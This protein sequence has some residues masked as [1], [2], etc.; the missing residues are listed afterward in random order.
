M[1]K[2]SFA[3]SLAHMQGLEL[4][5]NLT[6]MNYYRDASLRCAVTCLIL[7]GANIMRYRMHA[8][9]KHKLCVEPKDAPNIGEH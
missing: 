7:K 1:A 5:T 6:P 2:Y 9:R 4:K 3:D 8:F